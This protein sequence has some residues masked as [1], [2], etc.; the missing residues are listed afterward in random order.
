MI[1]WW[2]L[3]TNLLW[4]SGLASALAVLGFSDWV[5]SQRNEGSRNT[6][7]LAIRNPLF[8]SGLAL[9]CL[10]AGLGA[11]AGWERALWLLLAIGFSL[12]AG[13]SYQSQKKD[14]TS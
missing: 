5:V 14:P 2:N 12:L 13:A 8:H 6:L 3:L 11:H 1:D 10:G 7:A 4:I 9:T